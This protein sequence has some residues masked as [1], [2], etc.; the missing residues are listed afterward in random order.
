MEDNKISVIIP[1]YNREKT[2]EYAINSV[3]EQTYLPYEIIVVDDCSTDNTKTIVANIKKNSIKVK[4]HYICLKANAGAQVARNEGV[5]F[6][7]GKWI[8][9]LDSD[10][11]WEKNKLELQIDIAKVNQFNPFIVVHGNCLVRKDGMS[12]D[13]EWKLPNISGDNVYSTLLKQPGPMFQAIFTSKMAIEKIG[14]LD[15]EV[16]SYQ[17]WDTAI[18]LSKYCKFIY[19]NKP[20][21]VYCLHNDETISKNH[22]RNIDGYQYII[23]K[24]KNDIISYCGIDVWIKHLTRQ[25]VMCIRHKFW[26][27]ADVY[28]NNIEMDSKVFGLRNDLSL[29]N[30]FIKREVVVFSTGEYSNYLLGFLPLSVVYFIDNDPRKWGAVF[31]GLPVYG[32][33][34]LLQENKEK[35]AIVI[36]SQY[37]AEIGAQLSEMGFIEN[38][39][40]WDAYK[41]FGSMG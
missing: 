32:A 30:R 1:A 18:S 41:A 14:Y 27:E 17:E 15:N 8:A 13:S 21:F 5:K 33:E 28:L 25:M 20:L 19:L 10:D 11:I 38:I 9:F 39:H 37:G 2:I 7:R 3:L 34:K 35:I 24:Y 36:A 4:I 22:K 40:Y 12:K 23:S 16:P 29:M 26:D 6:A 31:K